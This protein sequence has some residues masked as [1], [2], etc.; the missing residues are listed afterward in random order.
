MNLRIDIKLLDAML[1]SDDSQLNQKG[2]EALIRL[3]DLLELEDVTICPEVFYE[4][5]SLSG[6]H[7]DC[8]MITTNNRKAA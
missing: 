8:I 5:C 7:T 4:Q 1:E 6:V 3:Q 2:L